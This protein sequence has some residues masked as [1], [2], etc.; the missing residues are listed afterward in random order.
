MSPTL[1]LDVK[2]GRVSSRVPPIFSA[3][4]RVK[5]SV[6]VVFSPGRAPAANEM[7]LAEKSPPTYGVALTAV[8]LTGAAFAV[9]AM[10]TAGEFSATPVL[11]RLT[12]V[13]PDG[14]MVTECV[15]PAARTA[16]DET[17]KCISVAAASQLTPE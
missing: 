4:V 8:G 6:S 15:A 11:G 7:E 5:S 17:T 13:E 2:P 12:A 10:V 3:D 14:V 16:Q 9:D 1:F